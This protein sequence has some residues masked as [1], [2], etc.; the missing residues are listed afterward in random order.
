[1]NRSRRPA[2]ACASLSSAQQS[3]QSEDL[4]YFLTQKEVELIT[5]RRQ[6]ASQ[7]RHLRRM[8][9]AFRVDA[10]GR[11]VVTRSSFE[12]DDQ[13]VRQPSGKA[14]RIIMPIRERSAKGPAL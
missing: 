11:P 4:D 12:S 3:T 10:D 13:K 9:M 7:R 2:E 5:G 1:M 6:F 8:G 14:G